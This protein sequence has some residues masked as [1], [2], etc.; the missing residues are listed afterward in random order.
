M[1]FS[2]QKLALIG[3]LIALAI[4]L[5]LPIL[6]VPNVE[7]F[8]FI[9]FSSGYLLGTTGGVVVGI[10]SISIYTSII[11]PYGLP[12]LPI[13]LAQIFC[14]GLIGFAGGLAFRLNAIALDQN[15][16]FRPYLSI[17]ILGIS[18]LV[19]TIIYDLFTNLATAFVVGQFLPVMIA[20]IPFALI[21]ILSNVI[22]FMVLAPLLMK[23]SKAQ[24]AKI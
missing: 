10:I 18:G 13:A 7:F 24:P 14:M 16:S 15:S 5:K 12:P 21:H 20:A 1:S 11:T 8:T 17:L 3:V 6:T 23:I 4:A 22:I 9:V 2:A 19:L